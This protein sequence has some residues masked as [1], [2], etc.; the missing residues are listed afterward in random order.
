[1][2]RFTLL[3]SSMLI[4][5]CSDSSGPDREFT[6]AGRWSGRILD[7][8]YPAGVSIELLLLP[9]DTGYVGVAQWKNADTILQQEPVTADYTPPNGIGMRFGESVQCNF[10]GGWRGGSVPDSTAL[11]QFSLL[12]APGFNCARPFGLRFERR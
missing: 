7:T 6:L 2:R 8:G 1:M 12:L 10:Y 9:F 5:S 11:A 4:A 3:V